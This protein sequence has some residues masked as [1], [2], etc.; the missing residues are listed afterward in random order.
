[1]R[2]KVTDEELA[3]RPKTYCHVCGGGFRTLGG[4][5]HLVPHAED[6]PRRPGLVRF[7]PG[8]SAL[9]DMVHERPDWSRKRK[10]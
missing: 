4:R 9:S 10:V 8:T 1:M 2:A 7:P 6:C 3:A 5:S